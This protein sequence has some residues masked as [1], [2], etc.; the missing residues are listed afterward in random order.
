MRR[1]RIKSNG[2]Q[3]TKSRAGVTDRTPII[4]IRLSNRIRQVRILSERETFK[5]GIRRIAGHGL[6]KQTMMY[7]QLTRRVSI[8]SIAREQCG[9][10]AA[11]P[12]IDFLLWARATWFRHPF[13]SAK[14]V[15]AFRLFPDP[16]NRFFANRIESEVWDFPS[17]WTR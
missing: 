11:S 3:K 6:L 15:E 5:A 7:G 17:G 4:S 1:E 9:L 2:L 8:R 13:G 16:V 10:A 12:K 14:M